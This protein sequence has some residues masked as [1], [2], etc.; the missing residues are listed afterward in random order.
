MHLAYFFSLSL[1][2]PLSLFVPCAPCAREIARVELETFP[3]FVET[4]GGDVE[5]AG[6]AK[7]GVGELM[8]GL[9]ERWDSFRH[10]VETTS[11]ADN[12]NVPVPFQMY[13]ARGGCSV[14]VRALRQLRKERSKRK[15]FDLVVSVDG[16]RAATDRGLIWRTMEPI[17]LF[18]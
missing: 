2:F 7:P 18:P 8:E 5:W 4:P 1:S 15:Y 13:P 16:W 3:P 12:R 11:G 9:K 10:F 6:I 14:R 17:L